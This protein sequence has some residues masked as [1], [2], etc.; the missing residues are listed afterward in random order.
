MATYDGDT[1][2][3]FQ[4]MG[5]YR[6]CLNHINWGWNGAQN[7][8]FLSSVLDAYNCFSQDNSMYYILDSNNGADDLNY[9]KD[10]KYYFVWR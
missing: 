3:E 10:V 4:N 9:Y 5:T 8:Y 6:T 7:G 2:V 1:W